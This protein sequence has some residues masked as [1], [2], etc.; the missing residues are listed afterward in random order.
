MPL[1]AA[2]LLLI[3]GTAVLAACNDS[4]SNETSESFEDDVSG[5]EALTPIEAAE[6]RFLFLTREPRDLDSDE[7]DSLS[8]IALN[9][10]TADRIKVEP[11]PQN[12][13][14]SRGDSGEAFRVPATLNR[15]DGSTLPLPVKT[16]DYEASGAISN[17]RF[18]YVVYNTPEGEL[19][20]ASTAPDSDGEVAIARVSAEEDASLI[21]AAAVLPDYDDP[22]NSAVLY[23]ATTDGSDCTETQWRMVRVGQ[24]STEAPFILRDSVIYE[25]GFV[26]P[27]NFVPDPGEPV[28]GLREHWTLAMRNPQGSL[29]GILTFDGDDAETLLWHDPQQPDSSET[30]ISQVDTWVKPLG[31]AG[32]DGKTIIQ[33][34]GLV[35][36]LSEQGEGNQR[37]INMNSAATVGN[38]EESVDLSLTGPNQ[39]VNL[40]GILYVVDVV[41]GSTDS[42]RVLEI[43]P[44]RG[45]E[46]VRIL[47]DSGDWGSR[48]IISNVTGA[49]EDDGFLAWAYRTGDCDDD[50]C[51]GAIEVLNLTHQTTSTLIDDI[52]YDFP[53]RLQ[54]PASPNP[55]T[56]LVFY[57]DT[58][59]N[60]IGARGLNELGDDYEINPANWLGQ[61]W[62]RA[63]PSAGP[64]ASHVF[65]AE[66]IDN[67]FGGRSYVIRARPAGNVLNADDVTFDEGPRQTANSEV[68]VQGYGPTVLLSFALRDGIEPYSAVWVAH[69]EHPDS[70]QPV[71]DDS[72][73]WVRPVP[74]F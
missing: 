61:A 66:G 72:R 22:H 25:D 5:T 42:G 58:I 56:P 21:C 55:D 13:E 10:G 59:P 53:Y 7:F 3:L 27:E 33:A 68:S 47:A 41:D 1:K 39:A 65:F 57:E 6:D 43:D 71:V 44:D 40:D 29:T 16:G 31:V 18:E 46:Q 12:N 45:N 70:L 36:G 51:R 50:S 14:L 20:R 23:Q 52:E 8:L 19:Y 74:Y 26:P 69:P 32:V 17:A 35:Y 48:F 11:R 15:P 63:Q 2:H 67:E 64:K 30:L 4:G 24:D 62:S 38:N 28:T 37:L 54:S 34:D 9:P 60:A 73:F 49:S